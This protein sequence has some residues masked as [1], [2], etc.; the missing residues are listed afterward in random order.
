[1]SWFQ[2]LG[3]GCRI[4]GLGVKE[5]GLGTW[6]QSFMPGLRVGVTWVTHSPWQAYTRFEHR[7]LGFKFKVFR[8]R[9]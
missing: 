2:V 4:Y 3:F 8:V 5:L 1:M 7:G 6:K 9:F